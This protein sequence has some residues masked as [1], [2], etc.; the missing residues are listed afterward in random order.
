M[1]PKGQRHFIGGHARGFSL[2]EGLIAAGVVAVAFMAIS[3]LFPTGYANI[4]Y[5]GN[6]TLAQSYAQQKIEQLKNLS[7]DAIDGTA[8]S[9]TAENLGNGFSRTCT[10]TINVGVVGALQGDMKKVQVTVTWPKQV[11]IGSLSVD[12]LFVR[13]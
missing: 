9:T 11:R 5:S 4:T 8:C 10:L 6:Q 3:S 13:Y 1:I 12:T 2:V 7:F